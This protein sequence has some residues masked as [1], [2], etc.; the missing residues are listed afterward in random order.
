MGLSKSKQSGITTT[1]SESSE[2][3]LAASS[4]LTA[5]EGNM[6]F[7]T[8]THTVCT[9]TIIKILWR[10]L[11]EAVVGGQAVE[12]AVWCL[13]DI[14][15]SEKVFFLITASAESRSRVTWNKPN[16][17]QKILIG[18]GLLWQWRCDQ[19]NRDGGRINNQRRLVN[20]NLKPQERTKGSRILVHQTPRTAASTHMD[21]DCL[22][23]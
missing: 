13:Y 10:W 12:R 8:H 21:L 3:T 5:M 11:V 23:W 9:L 14:K 15:R 22:S 16:A 1:K 20:I 19:R 6:I 2:A 17:L 4:N 18:E 7:T